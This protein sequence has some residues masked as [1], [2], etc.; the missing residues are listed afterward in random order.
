[1]RNDADRAAEVL[2]FVTGI[3]DAVAPGLGLFFRELFGEVFPELREGR[4]AKFLA[5]VAVNL[6]RTTAKVETMHVV[7]ILALTAAANIDGCIQV[8]GVRG[9]GDAQQTDNGE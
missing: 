3:G 1:M 6:E 8:S 9:A 2:R 7:R 4:I 5:W